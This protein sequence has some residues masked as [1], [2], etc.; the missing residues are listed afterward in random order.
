MLSRAPDVSVIIPAYNAR[1]WIRRAIESVLRQTVVP[2]TV[3]V[4]DDGSTDGTARVVREYGTSL[5]Y[6]CQPNAGPSAARNLGINQV[7]SD[8]IAF[9][10][11]DDEWLSHKI[12]FQLQVLR[13]NPSLQ[14]CSCA[15]SGLRNGEACPDALQVGP[16]Q[17]RNDHTVVRYFSA[18]LR[19]M[20][21]QTSSY[22][23]RRAVFDELGKF[24]PE[25]RSGEDIDMWCRIALRYP[26]IGYCLGP[27][28]YYHHDNPESAYRKGR[29]DRN[30]PVRSFCRNMRLAVELG[31]EVAMEFLPYAKKKVM[32][33]LLRLAV[34]DCTVEPETIEDVR[35]L[36]P[37]AVHEQALLKILRLLPRALSRKMVG[38][39]RGRIS[40]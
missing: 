32:D 36:F 30:L 28:Y 27:C 39:L 38:R 16:G 11:A 13:D 21:F 3:M 25:L 19:G 12:E 34:G 29:V 22:I 26:Q 5:Q 35:R 9:L 31:P 24:D 15:R 4:V 14:W 23:I 6:L 40:L 17:G 2:A 8:W 33:N 1:Q 20:K 7:R 37:L 18:A 10:D